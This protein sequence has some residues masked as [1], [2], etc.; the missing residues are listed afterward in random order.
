MTPTEIVD[1]FE[2][3]MP[4]W[5]PICRKDRPTVS[6]TNLRRGSAWIVVSAGQYGFEGSSGP[7]FTVAVNAVDGEIM[8]RDHVSRQPC[9]W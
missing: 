1:F 8:Q 5:D 2:Q 7:G 3:A 9:D 4:D 6:A